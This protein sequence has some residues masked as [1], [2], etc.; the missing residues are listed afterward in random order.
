MRRMITTGIVAAFAALALPAA[1][2]ARHSSRHTAHHASARHHRRHHSVAHTVVFS[3]A[4]RHSTTTPTPG[5]ETPPAEGETAGTIASFEGGVLKI[6]LS[7]GTTVSGK[8]T[9]K[10]EIECG[11]PG[12]EGSGG[13]SSSGDDGEGGEGG[14]GS[15]GHGW[16]G[17]SS[18]GGFGGRGDDFSGDGGHS[19]TPSPSGGSTEEAPSCGTASL[20][21]GAKVQEAELSVSS[22]GAVWEKVDLAH[23]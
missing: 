4:V 15:D 23:S 3:P 6:T 22:A 19:S 16:S 1:A 13:D 17:S 14:E 9:E 2:T 21:P 18:S 11:C 7:D 12:H 20:V 8:V 10:T 5:T